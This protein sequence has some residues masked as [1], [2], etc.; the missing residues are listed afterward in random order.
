MSLLLFFFRMSQCSNA[1]LKARKYPLW[2][3]QVFHTKKL[4][5]R[6]VQKDTQAPTSPLFNMRRT[7]PKQ[8]R[9]AIRSF[10][11]DPDPAFHFEADA[12]QDPNFQF[13]T[14]D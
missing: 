4:N 7:P 6:Q 5:R 13:D 10:A 12:D 2:E 8:E 9:N 14:S 3:Y 1:Y 11:A